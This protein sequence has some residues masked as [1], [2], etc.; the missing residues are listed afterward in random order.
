M[1]IELEE[2]KERV[3]SVILE[4]W[5]CHPAEILKQIGLAPSG[6]NKAIIMKCVDQLIK[7]KKVKA[8]KLG[9]IVVFWPSKLERLKSLSEIMKK[10]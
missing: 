7:E 8:K 2:L 10:M 4:R 6:K 5:P 1:E 3:L 9:R